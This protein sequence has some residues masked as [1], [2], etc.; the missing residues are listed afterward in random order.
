MRPGHWA[1]VVDV[2]EGGALVEISKG[3]LPG[4]TVDLQFGTAER[5]TS[6]A[7]A[8]FAARSSSLRLDGRV[9]TAPRSPSI[10]SG[11]VSSKA[12]GA[13]IQFPLATRGK[14][15]AERV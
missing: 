11:P 6:F 5:Q 13:S 1:T 2:S 8:W 9:C 10:A 14:A 12:D 15:S 7:D 3:L 4:A